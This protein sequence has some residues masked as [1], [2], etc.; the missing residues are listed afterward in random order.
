[1]ANADAVTLCRLDLHLTATRVAN[2]CRREFAAGWLGGASYPPAPNPE[3]TTHDDRACTA[4]L[5]GH[6]ILAG[7]Q[8][9]ARGTEVCCRVWPQASAWD[10]DSVA[11]EGPYLVRMTIRNLFRL[12][13]V[14]FAHGK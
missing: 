2:A 13:T 12:R 6:P 11:A 1:V 8:C 7:R 14:L 10:A 5:L 4:H 9:E 3:Q